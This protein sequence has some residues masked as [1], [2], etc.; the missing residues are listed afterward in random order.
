MGALEKSIANLSDLEI[1]EL[2]LTTKFGP[3]VYSNTIVS[4]ARN[5]FIKIGLGFNMECSWKEALKIILCQMKIF[6]KQV[7]ILTNEILRVCS[8]IRAIKHVV[9]S[10]KKPFL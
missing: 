8:H 5:I 2:N 10:S 1:K 4:D 9:R 7:D 6:E 3:N